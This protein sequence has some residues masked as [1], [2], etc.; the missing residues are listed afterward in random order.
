MRD[1]DQQR[2]LEVD[3]LLFFNSAILSSMRLLF[4]LFLLVELLR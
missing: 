1:L 4:L 2:L 3:V